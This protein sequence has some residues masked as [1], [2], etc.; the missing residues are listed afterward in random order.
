MKT[1]LLNYT[2]MRTDL[3]NETLEM[4]KKMLQDE[5]CDFDENDLATIVYLNQ[6]KLLTEDEFLVFVEKLSAYNKGMDE[7]IYRNLFPKAFKKF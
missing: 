7:Q 6:V 5:N 2:F 4:A 1:T 3:I